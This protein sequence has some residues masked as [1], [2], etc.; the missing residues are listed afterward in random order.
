MKEIKRCYY[1]CEEGETYGIAIIAKSV[2]EAKKLAFRELFEFECEWIYLRVNWLKEAN[3]D[4]LEYGMVDD[5]ISCKTAV[6]R[7]IYA[8][9]ES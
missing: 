7:G 9:C 4:G 6:E 1:C 5:Q 8:F 2:K 3:I